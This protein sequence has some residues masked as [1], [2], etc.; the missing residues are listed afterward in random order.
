MFLANII[1]PTRN[2]TQPGFRFSTNTGEE[3]DIIMKFS[4]I[5]I[6]KCDFRLIKVNGSTVST[7]LFSD[8]FVYKR[9][10]AADALSK[11]ALN[12][13]DKNGDL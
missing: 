10:L 11:E 6:E 7:D 13:S 2:Q 8:L 4:V 9:G 1:R 5:A 3:N 12:S